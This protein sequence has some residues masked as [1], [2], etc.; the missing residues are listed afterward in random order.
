MLQRLLFGGE[1]G[2][3]RLA[4]A[5]LLLLRVFA[6]LTLALTHGWSKVT[7]PAG[8]I[9]GAGKLGFP[10]PTLSGWAA[11]LS[12]FLG[13]ILLALGLLTRP[14][15][16]F[17]AFTMFVAAALVHARD[18][19]A[20]KEMALLY[21]CIALCFMLTGAGRYGLDTLI[22]RRREGRGFPVSSSR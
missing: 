7:D 18:P 19:F 10:A 22:H 17:I 16:F 5:G 15:A 4:D 11:A 2:G 13:G 8:I 9:A 21:F 1:G 12:E 20:M 14:A 3:S 6:G